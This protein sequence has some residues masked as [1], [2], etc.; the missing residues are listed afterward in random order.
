[1]NK[2]YYS[3]YNTNGY[4]LHVARNSESLEAFIEQ[5]NK[6]TN[7]NIINTTYEAEFI[8]LGLIMIMTYE[9]VTI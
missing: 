5:Y 6:S 2:L 7:S 1:M 3:I 8:M 4:I 9:R